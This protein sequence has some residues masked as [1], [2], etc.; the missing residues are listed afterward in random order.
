MR[1]MLVLLGAV[2]ALTYGAVTLVGAAPAGSVTAPVE[3]N[4]PAQTSIQAPSA[5]SEVAPKLAS[6]APAPTIVSPSATSC[7][8]ASETAQLIKAANRRGHRGI[9]QVAPELAR[10]GCSAVPVVAVKAPIE[11]PRV[12]IPP[13]VGAPPPAREGD[14][15]DD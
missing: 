10:A 8:S 14:D 13:G 3:L 1:L 7:E 12:V 5:N 11:L 9:V 4:L 6:T 15:G 2:A